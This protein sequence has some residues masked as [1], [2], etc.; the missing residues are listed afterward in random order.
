M[1]KFLELLQIVIPHQPLGFI[2]GS[3]FPAN[4]KPLFTFFVAF[5]LNEKEIQWLLS[6]F[7]NTRQRQVIDK[8]WSDFLNMF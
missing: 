8:F 5:P 2:V 1:I 4:K 3:H 7:G 6:I